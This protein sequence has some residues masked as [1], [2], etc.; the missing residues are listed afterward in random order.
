MTGLYT[1]E[2]GKTE[3]PCRTQLFIKSHPKK[4]IKT[5]GRE[6]VIEEV[7]IIFRKIGK[8]YMLRRPDYEKN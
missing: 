1:R 8:K 6:Y 3:A 7:L 5:L 2:K 4:N